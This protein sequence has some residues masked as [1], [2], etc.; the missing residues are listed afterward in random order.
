M[1]YFYKQNVFQLVKASIILLAFGLIAW[2]SDASATDLVQ[3]EDGL[4]IN[5][6]LTIEIPS[7]NQA[8]VAIV[9]KNVSVDEFWIQAPHTIEGFAIN[10]LALT[11]SDNDGKLLVVEH[12]KGTSDVEPVYGWEARWKIHCSGLSEFTIEYSVSPKIMDWWDKKPYYGYIS[13][14]FAVF[15]AEYVFVI[16]SPDYSIGS[17]AVTFNVPEGWQVV[18]PWPQ[19]DGIY[20]PLGLP[21]RA[22][23]STVFQHSIIGL[24]PFELYTKTIGNAEVPVGFYGDWTTNAMEEVSEIV[25]DLFSY[26]A[27]VWGDSLDPPYIVIFFPRISSDGRQIFGGM[28]QTG[29]LIPVTTIQD[30]K[31]AIYWFDP[32]AELSE[33]R[34]LSYDWGF[35]DESCNWFAA[36]PAQFY[37]WKSLIQTRIDNSNEAESKFRGIYDIYVNQYVDTNKDW[38][39]ASSE[40]DGDKF[41]IFWKGYLVTLLMSKEIYLQTNGNYTFDDFSEFLFGKYGFTGA[42]LQ[43]EDIKAEL[44]NLTGIDFTEFFNKYV[45]DSTPLP[46]AWAFEDDDGD[47]LSNALEIGWNTH[48]EDEDTDDDGVS[49]AKEVEIGS[50]PLDPSSGLPPI[51]IPRIRQG[52]RYFIP[53]VCMTISPSEWRFRP[54]LPIVIDGEGQ[55]WDMYSPVATDPQGDTEI[56]NGTDLKAVF[57]EDGPYHVYI[58]VEAYNPPLASPGTVELYMDVVD[59]HGGVERIG[60]NIQSDGSFWMDLDGEFQEV[61]EAVVAWKSVM[62]LRIPRKLLG[63]PTEVNFIVSHFWSHSGDESTYVDWIAP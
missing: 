43:E 49:D 63:H 11:A 23:Q 6:A 4:D 3:T 57:L 59:R 14:D 37:A 21:P 54:R 35:M 50:D 18:T 30:G 40:A 17:V 61:Q 56:G 16:P 32:A 38:A 15:L 34:W 55:D 51:C 31:D 42:S 8:K 10:V 52:P 36:G 22:E 1:R 47:G 39:L 45:Y 2:F 25:W 41:F 7:N 48:P 58:M 5:Y 46:M 19:N 28:S 60:T 53:L 24:G 29:Q 44:F 62:E 12:F 20:N 33:A 27:S 26:H 13:D 9:V